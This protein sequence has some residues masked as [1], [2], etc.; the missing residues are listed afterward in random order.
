MPSRSLIVLPDDSATPILDAIAEAS[1]SV[2]VKMFALGDPKLL[3]ALIGAKRRGVDVRVIYNATRRNGVD[4]N[5]SARRTLERAGIDAVPGNPALEITHEKSMVI[6][7]ATAFIQS[8]NW[9]T[10]NLTQTRDYAVV[11]SHLREVREI[12]ACFEADWRRQQ[13]VSDDHSTLIWSPGA[14]PRIAR[15]IDEA[16]HTLVV[17]NERY[18]DMVMIEHLVRART[19]GVKV[20]V[21]TRPPHALKAEKLVEGVGALRILEDVGAKVRKVKDLKLHAKMLLADGASAIVGSIN[22]TP[23]SLDARRELAIEVHDDDIVERLEEIAHAD[24]KNSRPLDLSDRAL[25]SDLEDQAERAV[26]LGI[27]DSTEDDAAATG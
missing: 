5:A 17:Q 1:W 9:T 6:D 13:F 16:R 12:V 18:Q 26:Q 24:W 11:T 15:F 14:R 7:E 10:K 4:D 27:V 21:M 19:R 23:G 20:H 2:R 3:R 22:L 8:F 25:L